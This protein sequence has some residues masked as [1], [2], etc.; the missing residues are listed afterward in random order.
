MP[1]PGC[2]QGLNLAFE[3][4]RVLNL[5]LKSLGDRLK[6][7]P[8]VFSDVRQEDVHCAATL[9]SMEV[10]GSTPGRGGTCCCAV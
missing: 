6:R 7:C 1:D 3:S 2:L 8:G 9:A 4:V 5:V 10:P